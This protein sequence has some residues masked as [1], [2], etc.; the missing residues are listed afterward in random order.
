MIFWEVSCFVLKYSA[1][2]NEDNE[3][4]PQTFQLKICD[5]S[6][7]AYNLVYILIQINYEMKN[8]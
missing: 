5:Y 8:H 6:E 4:S 2:A 3:K 1:V 7:N